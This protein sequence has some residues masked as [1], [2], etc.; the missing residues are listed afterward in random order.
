MSKNERK[1]TCIV[2][3]K[4]CDLL[5]SFN[6][7]GEITDISGYTCP[8]GKDYAYAECTAPVR[9]VTSTVR[10]RDGEVVSVKTSAPIPKSMIFDVMEEINSVSAEDDVKIGD[11]IIANVLDTGADV[12]ATSNRR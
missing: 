1:L 9:T 10:C 7:N 11:V 3:P 8:R 5:V 12:V 4:G 6:E 2:C